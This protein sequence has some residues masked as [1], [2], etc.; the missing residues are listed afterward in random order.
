MNLERIKMI[1]KEDEVY[2]AILN[3]FGDFSKQ[4]TLLD[5]HRFVSEK[6]IALMQQFRIEN[7]NDRNLI[8]NAFVLLLALFE[9]KDESVNYCDFTELSVKDQKRV[10]QVLKE[11]LEE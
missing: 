3:R 10:Q 4:R 8:E 5:A 9:D 2:N 7:K 1:N 6:I 11:T